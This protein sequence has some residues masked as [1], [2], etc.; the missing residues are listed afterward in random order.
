[1]YEVHKL[2]L[3]F[4]PGSNHFRFEMDENPDVEESEKRT[5][6]FMSKNKGE[7]VVLVCCI[8]NKKDGPIRLR[9]QYKLIE[10]V[11]KRKGNHFSPYIA[12]FRF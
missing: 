2:V 5:L 10:K 7:K 4:C 6:I 12:L 8:L 9:L 1:M 3:A 11:L